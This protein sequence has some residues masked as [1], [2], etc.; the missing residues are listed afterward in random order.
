MDFKV[1][2]RDE[3][4]DLLLPL[5]QDGKRRGLDAPD[6]GEL[7]APLARVHR[8]QCAGAVDPD[9]PV[10]LRAADGGGCERQHLGLIAKVGKSF[11]DRSLRH[12]LK[13]EAL[14]R[15]FATGQLD[16]IME[17]QFSLAARITGIDDG[18]D[19]G[20]LEQFLDHAEPVGGAGDGLKLEL[21]GNDRERIE[22]PGETLAPG[23]LVREAELHQVT[24]RR[25]DDVIINL[26]ELGPRSLTPQRTGQIGGD[27]RLFGD[28]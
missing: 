26:K 4:F 24:D 7:E 3:G 21:L 9:Q 18:G 17:N 1:G 5:H 13:P 8:S 12:R 23:H 16:D 25:S 15:L 27:A 22:L 10:A 2:L 14:D 6:R 11:L 20:A 28:D 19:I